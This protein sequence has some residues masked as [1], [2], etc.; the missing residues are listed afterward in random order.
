LAAKQRA[1]GGCQATGISKQ[2]VNDDHAL[3]LDSLATKCS[4][5]FQHRQQS[6]EATSIALTSSASRPRLS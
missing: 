6:A 1:K 2:E 5:M 4:E 3:E